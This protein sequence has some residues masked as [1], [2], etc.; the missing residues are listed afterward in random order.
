MN[1]YIEQLRE[2]YAAADRHGKTQ[3]LDEFCATSLQH[4]KH[5]IRVLNKPA[6]RSRKRKVGRKKEFKDEAILP[7]LKQVWLATN[8]LC[9]KRLKAA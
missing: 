6:F 5:A 2:R 3:I 1:F 8:Q 7:P 9:S 4:R